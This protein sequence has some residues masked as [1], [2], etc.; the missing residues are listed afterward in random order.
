MKL[1]GSLLI[2][3]ILAFPLM[4]YALD[5]PDNK[6]NQI[7]PEISLLC[8]SGESGASGTNEVTGNISGVEFVSEYES[9]EQPADIAIYYRD[10]QNNERYVNDRTCNISHPSN[11]LENLFRDDRYYHDKNR[12]I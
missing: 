6:D 1:F 9:L 11:K 3:G 4:L 8:F 7:T 12:F 5:I 2:F 10:Y